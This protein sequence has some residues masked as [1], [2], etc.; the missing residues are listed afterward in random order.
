MADNKAVGQYGNFSERVRIYALSFGCILTQKGA[1][2]ALPSIVPFICA[3]QMFSDAEKALL[4][5]GFY[6]GYILSQIPGA[7]IVQKVSLSR[8]SVGRQL[9]GPLLIILYCPAVVRWQGCFNSITRRHSGVVRSVAIFC[10]SFWRDRFD[11]CFRRGRPVP[12][13]TC[14]RCD[15]PIF[16]SW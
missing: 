10:A 8:I 15:M 6:Q 7:S 4:L 14:A 13:P 16:W 9:A 11:G 2:A 3:A 12:R 5:S 1:R